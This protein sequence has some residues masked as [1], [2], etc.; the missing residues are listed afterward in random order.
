SPWLLHAFLLF[1]DAATTQIYTLSLHDALPIC[2][3]PVPV[4]VIQQGTIG[5]SLGE[6]AIDASIEAAVIGAG[7]TML[8]M[9]FFY[10]LMGVV[11]A[12]SLGAY[13][14]L[15]YAVLSWM[16]ATL[17]LPGI[18]GF[19]LAIGM[20]V[21]ANVLVYERAKEEHREGS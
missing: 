8:Y 18:A 21:D 12:I 4:E 6:A 3:L 15:S 17:T 1:P 11:A 14:L 13:G 10:R 9:I 20:A 7:L 19:V 5:P 2:S 16:G